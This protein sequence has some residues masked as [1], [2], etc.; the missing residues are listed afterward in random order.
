MMIAQLTALCAMLAGIPADDAAQPANAEVMTNL[1]VSAQ[2]RLDAS[3]KELNALRQQISAEKLPMAQEL[4]TLEDQLTSLRKENDRVT[5]LVDAGNLEMATIKAE[6]KVRQDELSYV[7]NILDEYARTFETK[8]NISELQYCGDALEKA[9]QAPENNTLSMQEKFARQT[10]FAEFSV[11]RLFDAVGGMKFQ[12]VGVDLQGTVADGDFALVG[13][14]ALFKAKNGTAAGLVVPQTGSTKPLIRPLEGIM[15]AGLATLIETGDGT[16]PLDPSRGGALKE[17]VQKTNIIH[18]FKKGGPIMWPLLCAS[19]ISLG[20]V[21]ERLFFL[22]RVRLKRSHKALDKF[23][24][25][26]TKGHIQEAIDISKSTKFFVV[27]SLGYALEHKETS[28]ESALLYSQAQE[29]KRFKRG[30]PILD[31]VITLAPLL[32]LLGTVTGMMGSFS[33]IGGELSSP[34]AITGGIAEALI[35]TAFGLGIAI[36][37]LLPFNFLNA[38]T[39]EARHELESAATQMELLVRPHLAATAA[40]Q[41]QMERP[42]RHETNG[43]ADFREQEAERKRLQL[44]KQIAELQ[45]ELEQQQLAGAGVSDRA[46]QE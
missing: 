40:P 7:G 5:R 22:F 1:S 23:F 46:G 17:L 35:A 39:E 8:I 6:I 30:I 45:M 34:G 38:R 2:D 21:L 28:L 20:T 10:D 26:V 14:V 4:T 9:K 29:L 12:G 33:L 37:S 44:R 31:T 24:A 43:E 16:M 32:G 42:G 3:V 27:R 41:T 19:I 15:Q 25:A 18:I 13:P 36:V 11:K